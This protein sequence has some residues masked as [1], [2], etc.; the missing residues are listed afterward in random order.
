MNM[1]VVVMWHTVNYNGKSFQINRIQWQ[2]K[3]EYYINITTFILR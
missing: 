3:A 2:L 1:Y